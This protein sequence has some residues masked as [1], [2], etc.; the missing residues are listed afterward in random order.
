MTFYDPSANFVAAQVDV[1]GTL[2]Q[3]SFGF[4]GSDA[5]NQRESFVVPS[6]FLS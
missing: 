1:C 6:Q 4:R 2:S 5:N 3:G